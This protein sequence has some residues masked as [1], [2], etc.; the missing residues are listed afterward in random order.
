MARPGLFWG[1]MGLYT[2]FYCLPLVSGLVMR[3]IFDAWQHGSRLDF[4]GDYY[5]HTLMPPLFGLLSNLTSAREQGANIGVA[6]GAGSLARILGPIFATTTLH[7]LP[8]LP[9]LTCTVVLLATAAI[10]TS[11][12]GREVQPV[13]AVEPA[14]P[15]N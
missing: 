12:M 7:F 15:R 9:Y 1:S 3:A 2:V 4:R 14:K 13:P 6:Q 8:P 11:K 10:F 5:T